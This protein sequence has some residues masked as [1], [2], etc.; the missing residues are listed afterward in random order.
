MKTSPPEATEPVYQKGTEE[1]PN[2]LPSGKGSLVTGLL[3]K[4]HFMGLVSHQ[5][6]KFFIYCHS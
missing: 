3:D 4:G 2:Y 6:F 5:N 1:T